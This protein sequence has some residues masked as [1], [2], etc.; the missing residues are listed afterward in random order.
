M[1]LF[2][3]PWNAIVVLTV[4][5]LYVPLMLHVSLFWGIPECCNILI[6]NLGWLQQIYSKTLTPTITHFFNHS[7][8][9]S[10][11]QSITQT[12]I[13]SNNH[14]CTWQIIDRL[15]NSSGNIKMKSFYSIKANNFLISF[16]N[17]CNLCLDLSCNFGSFGPLHVIPFCL[18]LCE[19]KIHQW[20]VGK[21]WSC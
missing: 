1:F 13:H 17:E 10:L 16:F 8:S 21:P 6:K 15:F 18:Y 19:A 4:A 3:F 12:I 11:T 2:L 7:L 9:Q 5:T 14:S 20:N